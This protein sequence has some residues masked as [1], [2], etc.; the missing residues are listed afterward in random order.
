MTLEIT[1]SDSRYLDMAA[2]EATK[3]DILY[4]HGCVA[5]SSGKVIAR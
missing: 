2:E 4:R 1:K 5:V 3:S